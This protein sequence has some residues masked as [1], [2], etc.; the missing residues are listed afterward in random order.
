MQ[1][2]ATASSAHTSTRLAPRN[3]LL[4]LAGYGIRVSVERGHLHVTDNV[5]GERREGLLARATARLKRLV[6]LGHTGL[7]SLDALRWLHDV[8]A[9]FVH[10]DADGTVITVSAPTGLDDARL[11]RA[12]ALAYLSGLGLT[13]A[14]DL[15]Q[16]KLEGQLQ[17]LER[18]PKAEQARAVIAEAIAALAEVDSPTALRVVESRAAAAYWAAWSRASVRFVTRDQNR[19]PEH[20][21]SFGTRVSPLTSSPRMA[22]NPA[23]AVLNYL[24][25]TLESETRIALLTMGLDPGMGLLHAD[26]PSRDSLACDVMEAIRPEVDTYVLELLERRAFPAREFFE[27]RT[28]T[29]RLVPL[30]TQQLCET[31]PRWRVVLGPVVERVAQMLSHRSA[32]P[33]GELLATAASPSNG[34]PPGPKSRLPTRLTQANRSAGRDGARRQPPRPA[35][36]RVATPRC[37]CQTCGDTLPA[38]KRRYCTACLPARE[39]EHL[40]ALIG[41]GPLALARLRA[42]GRDPTKTPEALAKVAATQR[43]RA[44]ARAEWNREFGSCADLTDFHRDIL[45]GLQRTPL[46]IIVKAT[47]LSLRYCSL[48]RRGLRI[49]HRRYWGTLKSLGPDI[50]ADNA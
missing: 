16:A 28:G 20:W 22:A 11:R 13:I 34:S 39:T 17:V 23:N 2:E 19:V 3:G 24:Y 21:R 45:P 40:E 37:V 18:L 5:L 14:R 41:E 42:E 8:G 10:I 33:L 47:G 25:A 44:A 46:A 43:Q 50:D 48:I 26:Q 9:A 27:T 15:I 6:V 1:A 4:V 30:L 38:R 32:H 7:V 12:Q 36:T 29:C 31:A 35:S 49:P